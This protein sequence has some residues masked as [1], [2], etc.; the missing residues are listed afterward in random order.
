[1]QFA[2]A[3]AVCRSCERWFH[4]PDWYDRFTPPLCPT[5]LDEPATAVIRDEPDS[6]QTR[7]EGE[8]PRCRQWFAADDWF[9]DMAPVPCCPD[10]GMVPGKLAY[11][12]SSGK[13][14][15]RVLT[16]DLTSSEQ[17]LG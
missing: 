13:R 16:V 8:C 9:D 5:C 2:N 7:I 4:C 10:C 14:V 17:W 11:V 12:Q 15:E 3:W 1:M 6:R